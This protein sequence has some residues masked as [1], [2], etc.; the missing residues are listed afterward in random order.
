MLEFVSELDFDQHSHCL[1]DSTDAN[2]SSLVRGKLVR[3]PQRRQKLSLVH[4]VCGTM[5]KTHAVHENGFFIPF[6][7][8]AIF[9][10]SDK[11]GLPAC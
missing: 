5:T 2:S 11:L 8:E 7:L 9:P 10:S 6:F 1:R 3:F 4:E